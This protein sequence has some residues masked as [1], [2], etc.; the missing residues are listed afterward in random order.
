MYYL[1]QG[2][3][4]YEQQNYEMSTYYF[5][6]ASDLHDPS[7][8]ILYGIALLYGQGCKPKLELGVEY[9]EKGIHYGFI[10]LKKNPKLCSAIKD[11]I[12]LSSYELGHCYENGIGCDKRI[13][14]AALYYE[15]SAKLGDVN[16]IKKIQS[17]YRYGVGVKR[18]K[19]K[20]LFYE[21]LINKVV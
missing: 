17:M 12:A 15:V 7:G 3:A 9:L 11:E 10:E 5:K 20:S 18:N 1:E 14:Q 2:I 4:Y 21:H 6:L 19:E 8:L 16:A 13:V